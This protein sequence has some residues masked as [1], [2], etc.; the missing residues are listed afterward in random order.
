MRRSK[1]FSDVINLQDTVVANEVHFSE[2][3]EA[4]PLEENEIYVYQEIDDVNPMAEGI[5]E[6]SPDHKN[7]YDQDVIAGATSDNSDNAFDEDDDTP[8]VDVI[9]EIADCELV[10]LDQGDELDIY[11]SI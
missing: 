1:G 4:N 7:Y 11:Q 5:Y 8:A 6:P 3:E 2:I 10:Q 9:E